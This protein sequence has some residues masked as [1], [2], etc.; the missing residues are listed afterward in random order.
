M[1]I[2][3]TGFGIAK[4]ENE[5]L[6]VFA[7]I[8]TLNS[9]FLDVNFK[10]PRN[11][12]ADSEI[13]LR[14]LLKDKLVR[15]KIGAALEVQYKNEVSTS[16][17]INR[18]VV[19]S[20]YHQLLQIVEELGASQH[21]IFRLALQ[22]PD[23]TS[24]EIKVNET[25]DTEKEIIH[26]IFV[27]ALEACE[28]YRLTEGKALEQSFL[29]YIQTLNDLLEKVKMRDP[30]RIETIKE[31]M[32]IKMQDISSN[33]MFDRN[34]FE[35]ELMYYIEKLDIT[36]EKVRLKQHLD[37]FVETLHLPDLSGKKLSFIS[38]EIGREINTI[39]SKANDADIQKYVVE[40]KEELEK[41][42]EQMANIL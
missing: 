13:E 9:K 25:G 6:T 33:E 34:R 10:L 5:Q 24:Q 41:I 18:D 30:K 23:A 27:E 14:N 31:K 40:M 1:I 15:G 8:K 38:Q 26:K 36:E 37:Y 20:Y 22:M 35:Q 39:G 29:H 4:L 17:S 11:F 32:H 12:P 19:K 3:M 7:E 16:V 28:N 21:D 2:S 42:K